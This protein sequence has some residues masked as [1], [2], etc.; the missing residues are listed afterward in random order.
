[1]SS[2]LIAPFSSSRSR[3]AF[4][5]AFAPMCAL[6]AL[7]ALMAGRSAQAADIWINSY[8]AV[9]LNG[10]IVEGDDVKFAQ[11][12]KGYPPGTYVLL[13]GPGG[14]LGV[15]V[16]I[17][18]IIQER[19]F[20][21]FQAGRNGPCASACALLVFSGHH[22]VVESNALLCFHTPYNPNTKEPLS[23]DGVLAL[24]DEIEHWGITKKQA[25][26]IVG[27]AP[28]S[29]IRCATEQWAQELGFQ[30]SVVSSLFMLW[31]SLC[32]EV[33]L[34]GAMKEGAGSKSRISTMAN[35][36][37][38]KQSAAAARPQWICGLP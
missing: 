21:T 15:A 37:Q 19:G 25:I 5:Y 3:A 16:D 33:L 20:S 7:A 4:P 6:A 2:C 17:G 23:W 13:S 12:T 29:G 8:G 38:E 22:V 24:A 1:M 35:V 34:S 32:H 10:W 11:V 31:R 30:Y 26:A 27:A 36:L 18:N 9:R 28:R 14:K